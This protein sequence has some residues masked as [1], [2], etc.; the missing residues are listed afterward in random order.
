MDF[1][2]DEI[3]VKKS[4]KAQYHIVIKHKATGIQV[5]GT[6]DHAYKLECELFEK[7]RGKLN[8]PRKRK[9]A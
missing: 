7:L 3:T 2:N 4:S 9:R 6:G 1:R 5:S 8:E